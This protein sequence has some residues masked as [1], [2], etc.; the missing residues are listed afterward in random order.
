MIN[1]RSKPKIRISVKQD[2]GSSLKISLFPISFTREKY[3]IRLDGKKSQKHEAVSITEV[4]HMLR[5]WLC[6]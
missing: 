2:D 3:W 6:K 5:S 4:T 1:A